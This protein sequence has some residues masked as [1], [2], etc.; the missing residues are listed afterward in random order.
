MLKEYKINLR[1]VFAQLIDW[2]WRV[3]EKTRDDKAVDELNRERV[4]RP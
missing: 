2:Y 3:K 4:S 1:S